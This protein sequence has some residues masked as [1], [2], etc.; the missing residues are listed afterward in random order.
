MRRSAYSRIAVTALLIALVAATLAPDVVAPFLKHP[1]ESASARAVT[2]RV[3]E[4]ITEPPQIVARVFG[5]WINGHAAQLWS[6]GWPPFA[7]FSLRI[8]LT[9]TPF[10]TVV[11]VLIFELLRLSSAPWRRTHTTTPATPSSETCRR[12]GQPVEE[13]A[14]NAA[15]FEGM[16][17]LCFHLEFE[18]DA[19]PDVACSD[20]AGCPWWTI[21]HLERKV[22]ELGLDPSQVL[23]EAVRR[24]A[25]ER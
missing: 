21:A 14:A 15:I 4:A 11:G 17:W 23:L 25:D 1:Q 19:D 22:K 3:F 5:I 16:H 12:C 20:F 8:I 24:H 2:E 9:S 18:H 10:W 13:N 6:R 7:A